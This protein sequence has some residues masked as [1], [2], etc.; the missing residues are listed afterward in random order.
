M[1]NEWLFCNVCESVCVCVGVSPVTAHI[2]WIKIGRD[3]A[4]ELLTN[5]VIELKHIMSLTHDL[6]LINGTCVCVYEIGRKDA[7]TWSFQSLVEGFVMIS[8]CG[9]YLMPG[10][11]TG[12]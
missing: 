6:L 3:G 1:V 9:E 7:F 12:D 2:D 4:I 10:W 8:I 5:Y 11:C